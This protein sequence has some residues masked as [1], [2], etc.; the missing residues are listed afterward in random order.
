MFRSTLLRWYERSRRDLPWRHTKDPYSI[1]VSEIMLQQTRVETVIPYYERFL[2]RF[3]TVPSLA[4]A[5]ESEVLAMWSGLGYYRRAR[6]L[7]Q[8]VREVHVQY[9]GEVPTEPEKRRT[10]PGIGRYTNGAIGSIAFGKPEP[11]VDGNVLRVIS[12][13]NGLQ[14]SPRE[15][16]KSIWAICER[17]VVGKAPGDFNQAL[18][19]LGATVCTPKTPQCPTCPVRKFCEANEQAAPLA[20]PPPKVKTPA[21]AVRLVALVVTR[22]ARDNAEVWLTQGTLAL[23]GGLLNLP[24]AEVVDAKSDECAAESFAASIVGRAKLH[25]PLGPVRHE[26]SH[27]RLTVDVY[28][29]SGRPKGEG[30]WVALKGLDEHGVST[31]TR[32]LLG[33]TSAQERA[34]AGPQSPPRPR[35]A[36]KSPQPVHKPGPRKAAEGR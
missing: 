29:C 6:L 21:K 8:G 14:A 34:K 28:T 2:A 3:P 30:R 5:S 16:E 33:A 20:Y 35:R 13:L 26:L 32:K 18:M 24:M 9:G 22:G 4:E 36:S 17:L 23:F 10:L 11:L 15:L 31:L 7:H 1:W 27:R 12:R 19:E 25:G